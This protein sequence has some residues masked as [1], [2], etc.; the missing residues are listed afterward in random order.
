MVKY[1]RPIKR[2]PKSDPQQYRLYRLENE[3]IGAR[4]YM[5]LPKRA[6]TT[7]VNSLIRAYGMPGIQIVF[8]DLGRWAA[9]WREPNIIVFGR[10]TTSR[11]LLTAAHEVAHHLHGWLMGELKQQDHGPEFMACYMSILDTSRMIPVVGMK[12]I[13]DSY[14]IEYLEPP[15]KPDVNKLRKVVRDGNSTQR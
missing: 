9:E 7:Y 1:R 12:A 13:C 3:A 4:H 2:S 10:K 8:E 14:G 15:S 6:L 11:D 5:R